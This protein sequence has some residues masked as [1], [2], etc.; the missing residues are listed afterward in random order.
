MK[1][2]MSI[3]VALSVFTLLWNSPNAQAACYGVWSM[4][5]ETQADL[6]V[7]KEFTSQIESNNEVNQAIVEPMCGGGTPPAGWS[8]VRSKAVLNNTTSTGKKMYHNN[9]GGA[10][11]AA[12]D[13]NRVAVG[14]TTTK[15]VNT[16]GSVTLVKRSAQGDVRF[17]KSSSGGNPTIWWSNEKIRYLGLD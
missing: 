1:K 14:T 9:N 15:Y 11:A 2:F 8:G 5:D 12:A 16:D 3:L 7:S 4:K 13:F 6:T 10:K 17:Y